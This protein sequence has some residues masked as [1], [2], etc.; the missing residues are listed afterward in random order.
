MPT[1]TPLPSPDTL[2]GLYAR[3]C[4]WRGSLELFTDS[5]ERI[6]GR[7]AWQAS[8][9]IG[10]AL[11][12]RGL[13]AGDR[14]A[15][16]C[17]P[18]ARHALAWFGAPLAGGVSCSL[19]VRETPERLGET[20]AWLGAVALIHDA[21][22]ASLAANVLSHAKCHGHTSLGISLGNAS[23]GNPGWESLLAAP[24]ANP[25]A[26]K[27]DQLAAIILSSGSTGRPKGVMHTQRTLAENA[28]AGQV[29]YGTVT[30]RD[31]ALVMMQPSFAAWVNVVVPYVAGCGKV[32]FGDAFT[33]G[34]FLESIARERITM[35]PA[36]PTMWR[37][38]FAE[39]IARYDLSSIK[40]VSI[41]GEP[42]SR[43]DLER[44][45]AQVSKGISSFYSSSEAGTGGAV[46]ATEADTLG[47]GRASGGKPDTTG[48]PVVGA[49]IRIVDPE[50][51][52]HDQLPPGEIG[53]I[54]V[55][56]PSL[57]VGYWQDDALTR[58]RFRDGWWRSGD[59][60]YVDADGDLF[61]LGRTDNVIN[62]GGMKVHGEEVERALLRH[63]SVA[64]AA[65]VGVAD[66]RWG[67]RIEAHVILKA[68]HTATPEALAT[69]CKL[70]GGL[71]SFKAP[72]VF[73]LVDRLPTGPTGKLYRRA[74]RAA[75]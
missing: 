71:A 24:P 35:A 60:G 73:H 45:Y 32:V 68:G 19:H 31:A 36:V 41:S 61:V 22:L 58:K 54:L 51:D 59:M 44:I 14:I 47:I 10:G 42:P 57:A 25:L 38:M 66:E 52:F 37:M 75:D 30:T 39:D 64:Q 62:T 29:L 46:L 74:L 5:T 13:A 33:P 8:L 2:A 18:S 56:G 3:A 6:A 69:F 21:D 43:A 55:S 72:K 67:Q 27:P 4:R 7:Q 50:G 34:G 1:P 49:D 15:F 48:R 28:K 16:L 40:N 20:L 17:K 23:D 11:A 65:V 26:L 63:P 12:A 9:A 70:E 53:E